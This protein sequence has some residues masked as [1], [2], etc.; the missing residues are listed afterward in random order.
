RD[1]RELLNEMPDMQRLTARVST[2]R[3][4]PRDLGAVSRALRLL[5]K[6]KARVT[7]RHAPLLRALESRLE[8]CPDLREALDSTLVEDPPLAVKEGGIIRRGCD[9]EL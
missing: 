1:L 3:A 9:K 2:G 5:P 4:T 7:A 6:L 8:L